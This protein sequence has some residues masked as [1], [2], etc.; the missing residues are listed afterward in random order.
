MKTTDFSYF[1]ER[2]NA[3]E[4]SDL[5]KQWFLKELSANKELRNEVKLRKLTDE[6]LEKQ[7][8]ISL[9]NKLSVIEERR[10]T[11]IHIERT[12]KPSYLKFAAVITGLVLIGS[13]SLF[14]GKNLN[15][16]QIIDRYFKAYEFPTAQRSGVSAANT[17][18]TLALEFYNTHEYKKAADLFNKVLESNPKDMQTVFLNGVSHI[19]LKK[20]PEA[21]Q[22]FVRVIDDQSSVL[23]VDAAKWY[24][25][26]CYLK[27][28]EKEK[29][30]KQ[31]EIVVKD[32]TIYSKDAK[33][34][35]RRFR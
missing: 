33:K 7:N 10:K 24:L 12:L 28:D 5:E 26:L 32:G 16:D 11:N 3:G 13:I 35:I 2:Y 25:A 8:I 23:F 34:I 29:A 14:S 21:K 9:R 27:T 20:F 17:D 18:F 30:I 19:E 1:I 6:V 4:M 22:S 15:S 31:F